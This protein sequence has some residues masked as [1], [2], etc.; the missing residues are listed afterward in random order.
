VDSVCGTLG[1]RTRSLAATQ[2][3]RAEWIVLLTGRI[4]Q[5]VNH[6]LLDCVHAILA[7]ASTNI[8]HWCDNSCCLAKV[9][10]TERTATQFAN[11][12]ISH[13]DGIHYHVGTTSDRTLGS[14][15]CWR[16]AMVRVGNR[17]LGAL[18][19]LL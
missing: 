10:S 1:S 13:R 6:L 4:Q 14:G 2:D 17:T 11:L 12:F 18:S 5:G 16:E 15:W 8:L 9:A 19:E 7:I 3:G